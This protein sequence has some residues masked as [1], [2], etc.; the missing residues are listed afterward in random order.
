MNENEKS[1]RETLRE[2]VDGITSRRP[3]V[4]VND[5][6][7]S[8]CINIRSPETGDVLTTHDV[9]LDRIPDSTAILRAV[10]DL[11]EKKWITPKLLRQFISVATDAKGIDLWPSTNKY[12]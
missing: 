5:A 4:F 3:E 9:R 1:N 6:G 8:V 2:L 11:T 12:E 7:T 10:M